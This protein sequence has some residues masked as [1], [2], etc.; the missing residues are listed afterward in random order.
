MADLQGHYTP[1]ASNTQATDQQ[2]GHPY[3]AVPEELRALPQWCVYRLEPRIGKPGKMEKVPYDFRTGN[4]ADDTEPKMWSPFKSAVAASVLG[5]Y[6]GVGFMFSADDPYVGVDLD[7]CR[8]KTTGE[9]AAWAHEFINA[10]DG[11]AEVSPSGT[12]V[13][14]I[15]RGSWRHGVHKRAYQGGQVEVYEQDRF[16]TVT[17]VPV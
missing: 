1:G 2:N 8:D 15:V 16:F 10:L 12:G 6:D 3:H 5:G 14:V 7:D 9:I 4:K 13:H 17:G 11:Y